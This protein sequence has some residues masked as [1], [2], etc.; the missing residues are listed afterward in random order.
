MKPFSSSARYSRVSVRRIAE[1]NIGQVPS[2]WPVLA[3][4]TDRARSALRV[5]AML[6]VLFVCVDAH[7]AQVR[8][9]LDRSSMQLGETVTLNVEVS[10]NT[11]ASQPDFSVLQPDFNLLGTQSSTS[12]NIVNGT[13]T[14][15]LLWAVGLEPKHAG[16]LTIP[17]LSVA[18][19]QTQALTLTVTPASAATGK[20]GDDLF[21]D[22][23][24]EPK[25]PYVQQQV[26]VTVKLYYALDLSDG[27][28]EDPHGEGLNSRKL[29]QDAGYQADVEGRRYRV[30]ERHYA[31]TAEKSG[32]A[33]MAPIVFRGHAV[34]RNDMNSFFARGRAVTA[35]V[36]GQTLEVRPRPANSGTDA[37]L[38][39]Q[40]LSLSADGVDANTPAHVGEPL[41]L[42]LRMKA[43]GLAFEQLPELKLPKIDG[44]DI[45]PD[46]ETTVNRED[47]TWQYGERT[48]KFAIVPNRTGKL[49][50]P[51][52]SLAWWDTANDR[53][54]NADLPALSLHVAAGAA[55]ATA[56]AA[57]GAINPASTQSAAPTASSPLPELV[58]DGGT[59]QPWRAIAFAALALWLLTALAW[60]GWLLARRRAAAGGAVAAAAGPVNADTAAARKAFL[61]ACK[62]DDASAVARALLA[63]ARSD[64]SAART[65]GELTPTLASEAQRAALN[66]LERSLY[67]AGAGTSS[68]ERVAAAFR[69]GF[70][71]AAKTQAAAPAAVPPLYP[72]SIQSERSSRTLH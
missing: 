54:A 47:G 52:L 57:P 55:N 24:V 59:A 21:L 2:A 11:S 8:A 29:G 39:A 28:L 35:R 50:I 17:A 10:D 13:A 15:K 14:S 44:A 32:T 16:A 58:L 22:V 49:T 61:D 69:N 3:R 25:S 40:S 64:G 18:G 60:A 68:G 12:M 66:D 33:T 70:E 63:W 23:A 45:Y 71:F 53:A 43:Q 20:A 41:T 31:L 56:G 42:T 62:R 9:W 30:L 72:F 46:K 36:E 19:A 1:S 65:L 67:A 6:A 51:P 48:R 5:I 7:A 26:R 4:M 34:N 38:P 27:N 37:W